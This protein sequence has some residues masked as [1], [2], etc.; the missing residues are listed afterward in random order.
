MWDQLSTDEAN[1]EMLHELESIDNDQS[2]DQVGQTVITDVGKSFLKN[3]KAGQ[4]VTLLDMVKN[5]NELNAFCGVRGNLLNA[6][7]NTL[8][9]YES[10]SDLKSCSLKERIA[11]T[12]CKLRLNLTFLCLGVLF[13]LNYSTCRHYFYRTVQPL[14]AIL[15]SGIYWPEKEEIVNKLPSCFAKYPS[16][17][18]ILDCTE[19]PVNKPKCLRCRILLYSHYKGRETIKLL[20]GIAP[21][22]LI[23]YVSKAY[24][25]RAS[26]KSIFLGSNILDRL[27]PTKDSIMVD[28]GFLIENECAERFIS[29][30]RPPFK[31]KNKQMSASDANETKSIAAARIHVERAIQ[32]IKIFKIMSG[33]IPWKMAPYFDNIAIIVA[34]IVNL[35]PPILGENRY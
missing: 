5:D 17:R 11:L 6:F 20:I 33:P 35:S 16:T 2:E 22:G 24:G 18:I 1:K 27:I 13:N 7:T 21:S 25:G 28:K 15:K 12:L 14:S 30:I 26:D 8:A 31:R 34:S 19:T 9:K 10:N 29:L 4:R 23:T 3:C 32:R